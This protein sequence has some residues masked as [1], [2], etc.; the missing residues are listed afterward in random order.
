M[1]AACHLEF[2]V[3]LIDHL[4]GN[5][6]NAFASLAIWWQ[7]QNLFPLINQLLDT[8]RI[9]VCVALKRQLIGKDIPL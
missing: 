5:Q 2:L 3:R 8:F 6:R 4:H 9:R 7:R 1:N